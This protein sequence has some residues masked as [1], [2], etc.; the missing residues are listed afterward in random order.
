MLSLGCTRAT[1][2]HLLYLLISAASIAE[3]VLTERD[4]AKLVDLL[5]NF[6]SKWNEIGLGLGFTSSELN[7]I[8]HKPLL[9]PNA[10][11]SFLIEL[12][13]QW[14]QWPTVNH[15]TKPILKT[16]CGTLCSSLVGLG[17][18]AKKVE[19][20]MIGECSKII[21]KGSL[22]VQVVNR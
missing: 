6:S 2:S 13:S 4:I 3:R 10:P 15:P 14:V 20:E 5:H 16:F 19:R 1:I 11:T 9:L 17:R 8:S 21:G 18:L 22:A 12:L 7:L